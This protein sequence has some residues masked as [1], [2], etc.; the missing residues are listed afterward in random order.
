M[1][2]GHFNAS[3]QICHQVLALVL[4]VV[5]ETGEPLTISSHMFLC[6]QFIDFCM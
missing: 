3:N 5:V 1:D 2:S 6:L 4:Y